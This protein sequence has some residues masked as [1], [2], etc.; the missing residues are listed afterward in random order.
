MNQDRSAPEGEKLQKIIARAGRASRREAERLLSLGRVTVNGRP[1]RLGDRAGKDARIAVDGHLITPSG[2]AANVGFRQRLIAYHKPEGELCTRKDSE[3]RATVFDRLPAVP[4]GRWL[5]V[6]RLDLNTS[7]LLLMTTDGELAN[8]L[9]HP[10]YELEREYLVRVRGEVSDEI[11]AALLAG[12]MLE[13]GMA[14]FEKMLRRRA[15]AGHAWFQ[16]LLREGRNREVR[17]LWESQGVQVSRLKRIRYGTQSLPPRLKQGHYE[18][19]VG[20]QAALLY[21]AVGLP[22]PEIHV[23]RSVAR[24]TGLLMP[25]RGRRA[26]R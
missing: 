24:K 12:V 8:R 13:D 10:S 17:R 26:R 7:G 14:R 16:V 9:M 1:A 15:S 4:G 21:Q 6:G 23:P 22:V 5:C 3:G 19:L 11:C 25:T 2:A 20:E 18:Y